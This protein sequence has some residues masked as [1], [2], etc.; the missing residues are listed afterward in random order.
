MKIVKCFKFLTL[1][2]SSSLA[3]KSRELNLWQQD[4]YKESDIKKLC[5][6]FNDKKDYVVNYRYL[7]MALSLGYNLDCVNKVLQYTQSNFLKQYI[8]LNTNLRKESKNEFQKNYYK[9]LNNSIYGKTMENIRHR[10][11]F[12]LITTEDEALRVKNLKHFTIFNNN[13]VGL[14]MNKLKVKLNK[15]IY[16]GQCI[17]DQSKITMADFHYNFMLKNID[18]E[19]INLMMTDTDS[20]L[21]NIKNQDI[22]KIMDKNKD[23][24]DLSN[25][26]KDHF[27]YNS[28]NNKVLNKF[29]DE[30]AGLQITN[31]VCLRSKLY[32]LICEDDI[33]SKNTCKGVKQNVSKKLTINDY[34][35]VRINRNILFNT[36]TSILT[37]NIIFTNYTI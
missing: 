15:P 6:T 35:D 31:A 27:L 11:Q 34:N 26:P 4:N 32:S 14:H 36:F 21:Y 23:K 5:L 24:F 22:Y 17:L 29:K 33:I 25:Y 12:R 18:R 19:N 9:L 2:A 7:K 30:K 10:I 1:N 28:T 8:M 3:I 20:F 16:L 37:N 13:L